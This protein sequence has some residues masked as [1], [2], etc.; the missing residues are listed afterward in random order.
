MPDSGPGREV[1]DVV[2]E[3]LVDVEVVVEDGVLVEEDVD[4]VVVV[5]VGVEV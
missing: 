5:V 2:E 3:E 4:V 1:V